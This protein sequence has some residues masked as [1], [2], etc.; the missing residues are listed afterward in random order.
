MFPFPG[1]QILRQTRKYQNEP[2]TVQRRIKYKY[3]LS[4][5]SPI[6]DRTKGCHIRQM[7]NRQI[8]FPPTLPGKQTNKSNN[9][10]PP[11]YPGTINYQTKACN[12]TKS[13][14]TIIQAT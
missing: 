8:N 6:K 2:F 12:Q 5:V 7:R 13:K 14:I 4:P 10:L 11:I 9:K 1:T 3:P